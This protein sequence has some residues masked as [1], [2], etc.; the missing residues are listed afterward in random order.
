M[1]KEFYLGKFPIPKEVW[2]LKELRYTLKLP[3]VQG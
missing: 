2:G 1:G 3:G